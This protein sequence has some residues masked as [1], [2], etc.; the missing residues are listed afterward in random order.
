M[1]NYILFA[2]IALV[3]AP[4]GCFAKSFIVINKLD[5]PVYCDLDS[6]LPNCDFHFDTN[7]PDWPKGSIP[8]QTTVENGTGWECNG[9]CYLNVKIQ[10]ANGHNRG[11]IKADFLP[12]P[13][14]NPLRCHDMRFT[15]WR[16]GEL[17]KLRSESYYDDEYVP[18]GSDVSMP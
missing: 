6:D 12:L 13:L 7:F 1:K 2:L 16:D 15:I 9:A 11:H 14:V 10:A 17:V 18:L 3:L 5:I 4:C 8:P